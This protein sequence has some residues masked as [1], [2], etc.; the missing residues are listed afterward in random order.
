MKGPTGTRRGWPCRPEREGDEGSGNGDASVGKIDVDI[1]RIGMWT[2][3]E[4]GRAFA[5][6]IAGT[7]PGAQGGGVDSTGGDGA[8][9]GEVAHTR[10]GGATAEGCRA[11]QEGDGVDFSGAVS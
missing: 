6:A 8:G 1:P 11:W 4:G 9:S 3:D 10:A 2:V 7:G 5:V